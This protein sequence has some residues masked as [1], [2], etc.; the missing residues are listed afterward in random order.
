MANG[1][2]LSVS[3]TGS[4]QATYQRTDNDLNTA[5]IKDIF[6][7]TGLQDVLDNGQEADQADSLYHVQRQFAPS[8]PELISLDGGIVDVFGN[9][10]NL[11][12]LKCLIIKNRETALNKYLTVQTQDEVYY[13]GPGGWR[14]LWEPA[15]VGLQ[16]SG[17]STA[18]VLGNLSINSAQTINYDLIIIGTTAA[19]NPSS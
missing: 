9:T 5:N 11:H 7:Y 6:S 13:I 17:A 3:F 10:L 15:L 19:V 1:R 18:G 16:D 4:L 12:A 2:S 8:G 14:V